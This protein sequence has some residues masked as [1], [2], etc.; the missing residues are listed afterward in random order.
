MLHWAVLPPA[1][2]VKQVWKDVTSNINCSDASIN[3]PLL[4]FTHHIKDQIN[5]SNYN[6]VPNVTRDTERGKTL[7]IMLSRYHIQ[8][9]VTETL[10]IQSRKIILY[11]F[12]ALILF[13]QIHSTADVILSQL[14]PST[15]VTMAVT[16]SEVLQI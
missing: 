9:H 14:A 3:L 13:A 5:L 7:C 4:Y 8:F 16:I 12:L 10:L 1:V 6:R 15:P 11:L 2:R